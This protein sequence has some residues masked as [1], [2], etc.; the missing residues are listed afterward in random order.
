MESYFFEQT[1]S[2]V[3]ALLAL[4]ERRD[5]RATGLAGVPSRRQTAKS[6]GRLPSHY[7][8]S[9]IS[10]GMRE[11]LLSE[12]KWEAA[13]DWQSMPAKQQTADDASHTAVIFDQ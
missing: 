9:M 3:L 6:F 7:Q 11:L 12:S 5:H 8:P 1:L 13:R 4:S 10:T 2:L